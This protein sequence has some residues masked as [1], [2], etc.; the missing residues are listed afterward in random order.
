[1][2]ML[3]ANTKLAIDRSKEIIEDMIDSEKKF[4]RNTYHIRLM[5][6]RY[7]DREMFRKAILLAIDSI[8]YSQKILSH[9]VYGQGN[10]Q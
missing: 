10:N 6:A 9:T 4:I 7:E 2:T 1:M 3:Y 8:R 5:S